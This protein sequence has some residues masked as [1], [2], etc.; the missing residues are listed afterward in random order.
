M[1][2]SHQLP[3]A[4]NGTEIQ[5]NRH[6]SP[7]GGQTIEKILLPEPWELG[8]YYDTWR[9]TQLEALYRILPVQD[10]AICLNAPTGSG[11]TAIAL[12]WAIIN[13]RLNQDRTLIMAERRTELDQYRRVIRP[14]ST[15]SGD[16]PGAPE[17]AFVRGRYNYHCPHPQ[18][19]RN[20]SLLVQPRDDRFAQP[21]EDPGC[22][23]P[24]FNDDAPC[25]RHGYNKPREQCPL[26]HACP[27]YRARDRARMAPVVVTT[28]AYGAQA[29]QNPNII[30]SFDRLGAD[31]AHDLPD[32]LTGIASVSLALT[33]L[34]YDLVGLSASPIDELSP[35]TLDEARASGRQ[36][37]S[38]SRD[39][40]K[41]ESHV[42]LLMVINFAKSAAGIVSK[43]LS[44][45][46]PGGDDEEEAALAPNVL[47]DLHYQIYRRLQHRSE[48]MSELVTMPPE[49]M[50]NYVPDDRFD[51]QNPLY[52]PVR[53]DHMNLIQRRFWGNATSGALIMSGTLTDD[54][55][56]YMGLDH[57][58]ETV[59]VST[60]FD[61]KRRP[62]LVLNR[63]LDLSYRTGYRDMPVL[64]EA[65]D[66]LLDE[67]ELRN[68]KG[69][70]LWPS[71]LAVNNY[72][73]HRA[74]TNPEDIPN[75]ITHDS[76]PDDQRALREF[77]AAGAPAVLMSP[78]AYQAID[79]PGDL[80]RYIIVPRPFWPVLAP[81]SLAWLRNQAHRGYAAATAAT[82]V[83]Q[84]CGRGFR[85][86]DDWCLVFIIDKG[87]KSQ[88]ISEIAKHDI[89][90]MLAPSPESM[91]SHARAFIRKGSIGPASGNR[92]SAEK[93]AKLSKAENKQNM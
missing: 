79:L 19:P 88:V 70:L 11:K 20:E 9:P 22:E 43:V 75:L 42:T 32:I 67:P 68:H 25:R 55:H 77:Q 53:L 82:R 51:C 44:E 56:T 49:Q 34:G 81:G 10:S 46:N 8:F 92:P 40:E 41:A 35:G 23:Q 3:Q 52:V 5:K 45:M 6:D 57:T 54:A 59:R 50:E 18:H 90:P 89:S 14:H 31:E 76:P 65:V 13:S 85:Q 1:K 71:Y 27:Y 37:I 2:Q 16:V 48:E 66:T 39:L 78:T 86:D 73:E 72:L 83:A 36:A 33:S 61:L 21:C 7:E 87:Y 74:H 38:L 64:Y 91:A 84:A 63:H 93:I 12:T 47:P 30:G 69:L 15:T 58:P 28:Y 24:H 17:V 29:L 62:V 26:Y 60:S 4:A 80:C